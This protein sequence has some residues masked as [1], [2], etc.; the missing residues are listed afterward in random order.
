[1]RAHDDNTIQNQ[2]RRQRDILGYRKIAR[3]VAKE[4]KDIKVRVSNKNVPTFLGVR[5]FEFNEC[6][7]IDQVGVV[8]GLTWTGFGDRVVPEISQAG[9]VR[10]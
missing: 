2:S 3:R 9:L 1:M 8:N 6:E 10:V 7:T 5:K 4:G